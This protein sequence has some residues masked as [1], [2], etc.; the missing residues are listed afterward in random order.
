M[1]SHSYA[2]VFM[3]IFAL[4]LAC[5]LAGPRA[6]LAQSDAVKQ[7]SV[8]DFTVFSIQDRAAEMPASIF[9]GPLTPAEKQ[10]AMPGGKAPAS[11]NVFIVKGGGRN[12]MIDAGYGEAGPGENHFI[13]RLRS[14]GFSP[15]DIDMVLLTHTHPD[16]I[17]GLVSKEGEAVFAKARVLMSQ[18]EFEFFAPVPPQPLEPASSPAAD[19]ARPNVALP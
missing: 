9:S 11:V 7:F 12:I 1:P 16:H 18:A 4:A 17:G 14:A 10:K 8:G 13:E 3:G 5:F 6:C 2:Y 19:E 15:D